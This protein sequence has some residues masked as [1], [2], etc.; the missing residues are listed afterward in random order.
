MKPSIIHSIVACLAAFTLPFMVACGSQE[1]S[2]PPDVTET[3]EATLLLNIATVEGSRAGTAELPDNEKMHNVRIIILHP[4]GT[5]EHNKFYALDGPMAQHSIL[6]KV[7]SNERKRV[8]LFANEESVT[9]IV[10]NEVAG[11]SL[12]SFL[13]GYREGA[14]GFEA[15]ANSLYFA[16]DYTGGKYIPMSSCY[17]VDTPG[18]GTIEKTFYVVRVATKFNVNF[19]NLRAETVNVESLSIASHADRNFL[20]AHVADSEQNRQLLNGKTWIEWLK[21][22]SDASSENDSYE[23]T[24]A[25][26]WLKDYS[27]PAQKNEQNVYTHPSAVAVPPVTF[28]VDHLD[29]LNAGKE[30]IMFYLPESKNLKSGATDGEQEYT[31]TIKVEGQTE[32][33]VRTLPNLKALFRNTNVVVNITMDQMLEMTVDVIPFTSVAVTPDFGLDREDFTG[34]IVGKD[35]NGNKC[36]YD[37]VDGP[38]YLGPNDAVEDFVTINGIEYMLVYGDYVYNDQKNNISGYNRTAYNLHHI[39]EKNTRKEYLLTPDSITGYKYGND[40]YLNKLKQR[41]WLDSGGD[42]DPLKDPD[43]DGAGDNVSIYDALTKVGLHLYGYRILFEWDRLDWN[44]ARY[45]KWTGIYP[46]YWFD[47]LGNRYP[48]S[49]GDTQEK[50]EAKLGDWVKYL[51]YP[52]L[53]QAPN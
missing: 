51:K 18:N 44:K 36:W 25:A 46:K 29:N 15:A 45:W 33:F 14:S 11:G 26:G 28:D 5:V 50:R 22:V 13:D 49:E 38:Y 4:D 16:P 1:E 37:G 24:E 8:F 9:D 48:W 10:V 39:I 27:L 19:Y 12:S 35:A 17:V 40:M 47:V 32:P 23:T 30:S 3:P 43:P 34:Y 21:E 52:N 7:A 41:V 31:V 6:L 2:F 53:T 20:M 42:P